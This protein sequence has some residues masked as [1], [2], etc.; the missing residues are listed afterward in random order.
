MGSTEM[1]KRRGRSEMVMVTVMKPAPVSGGGWGVQGARSTYDDQI[2]GELR[3]PS[4]SS[5]TLR[6]MLHF[7]PPACCH[8][9]AHYPLM[10][11]ILATPGP[12]REVATLKPHHLHPGCAHRSCGTRATMILD[13]LPPHPRL[14]HVSTHFVNARLVH[15]CL[16][17]IHARL[18]RR[19]RVAPSTLAS[20][21]LASSMRA[22]SASALTFAPA[23][24]LWAAAA[25]TP[26]APHVLACARARL[27]RHHVR[28]CSRLSAHP[29][30]PHPHPRA[31]SQ[32]SVSA[33]T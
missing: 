28:V 26:H 31:R 7:S 29:Q 25:G 22:S 2:Q 27:V 6:L 33:L 32:R 4:S 19:F 15:A 3:P 11:H 30:P 5:F 9:A 17:R 12:T 13:A 24:S 23:T 8:A 14:V 20:S 16:V 1:S 21:S 18:S 10:L